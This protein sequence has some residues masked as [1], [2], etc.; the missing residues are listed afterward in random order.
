MFAAVVGTA[1][2]AARITARTTATVTAVARSAANYALP[3]KEER[4][5]AWSAAAGADEVTAFVAGVAAVGA[6]ADP[7]A[8][9]ALAATAAGIAASVE[10]VFESAAT[11]AAGQAARSA[12][13]ARR[14]TRRSATGTAGRS[15]S[16][17]ARWAAGGSA[18]GKQCRTWA[19]RS[20]TASAGREKG[21]DNRRQSPFDHGCS[22]RARP[23]AEHST[24]AGPTIGTTAVPQNDSLCGCQKEISARR[25]GRIEKISAIGKSCRGKKKCCQRVASEARPDKKGESGVLGMTIRQLR[26]VSA[27]VMQ[28]PMIT[29]LLSG[30][31][32]SGIELL[33][34]S[35]V[36]LY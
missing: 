18:A 15:T 31:N 20:A 11:G 26:Q 10:P 19:A 24:T 16:G 2:T 21:K 36:M 34:N 22:F 6:I 30:Q 32:S 3:Q 17:T 35:P 28:T 27:S 12:G 13:V 9:V 4:S 33:V 1:T 23:I 25:I 14:A 8:D 7:L 29:K 5:W